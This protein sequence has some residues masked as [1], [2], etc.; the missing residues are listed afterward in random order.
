MLHERQSWTLEA[1][2]FSVIGWPDD[3]PTPLPGEPPTQ[4]RGGI[5]LTA[6]YRQYRIKSKKGR[7]HRPLTIEYY[8][9]VI[10]SLERWAGRTLFSDEIGDDLVA[11]YLD[12]RAVA[13]RARGKGGVA[14]GT[15][16]KELRA[17]HALH[18]F[19]TQ[20]GW[21]TQPLQIE[22]EEEDEA[23]LECWSLA[24]MG[25]IIAQ[26]RTLDYDICGFP[27]SH[28]WE[29]L[30]W[31]LYDVGG[32]INAT[33]NLAWGKVRLTHCIVP[34]I[35]L[36]C[37]AQKQRRD[38]VLPISEETAEALRRLATLNG[39]PRGPGDLVFP[40]PYDPPLK[41]TGRRTWGRLRYHFKTR[42]LQPLGLPDDRLSKFHKIRRTNGTFTFLTEGD[43]GKAQQ[44][45]GHSH[46][47][48][49]E[50]YIDQTKVEQVT[51]TYKPLPRPDVRES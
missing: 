9:Q 41:K 31:I 22:E 15:R 45:L 4:P 26:A 38:Q 14:V 21:C 8:E 36:P 19:A 48:V 24:E 12:W 25:S 28:W 11:E 43:I 18:T 47:R 23:N 40:W 44:R 3:T 42:I 37:G 39:Q 50:G 46:V 34:T 2:Q 49:T 30:F 17:L 5:E 27:A 6:L 29:A 7:S 1:R 13:G 32:R 33:M 51:P 10:G 20:Q 16:N 35:T